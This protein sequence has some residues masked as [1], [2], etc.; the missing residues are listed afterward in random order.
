VV[1]Y[2]AFGANMS[3]RVL[4][5]RGIEVAGSEVAELREH[6]LVFDQRGVWPVEPAFASFVPAPGHVVWGV[7]YELPVAQIERLD[8]YETAN[9]LPVEVAVVGA[10][11]GPTAARA[12]RTRRPVPERRPSARYLALICEGAREHGLPEEYVRELAARP[13]AYVPILSELM[14]LSVRGFDWVHQMGLGRARGR[15]VP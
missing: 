3:T 11:T 15:R 12:Y 14:G 8:R 1:R 9:Y 7:L 2:F 4:A 13:S 5:R 10:R 6:R